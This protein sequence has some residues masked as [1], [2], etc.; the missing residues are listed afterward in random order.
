MPEKQPIRIKDLYPDF[1]DE[2]LAEAET[3]LWRFVRVMAEIY[4]E[5]HAIKDLTAHHSSPKIPNERSTLTNQ[6]S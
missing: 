3:K 5:R 1:T 4:E 6:P 2:Q